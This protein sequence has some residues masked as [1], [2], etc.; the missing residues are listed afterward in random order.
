M[1]VHLSKLSAH[2]KVYNLRHFYFWPV[3]NYDILRFSGKK[4]FLHETCFDFLDNNFCL[5]ILQAKKT[6]MTYKLGRSS[7]TL[8]EFEY[9]RR[10]S[11]I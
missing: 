2:A 6:S 10:L 7:G 1:A 11:P 5:E 8:T 4:C 3:W 9:S